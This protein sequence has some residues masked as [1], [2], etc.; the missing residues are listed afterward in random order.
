MNTVNIIISFSGRKLGNSGKIAELCRNT[1]QN[2]A[3]YFF[4]DFELHPCGDCNGECFENRKS[5]P[6]FGD[7]EESLIDAICRSDQAIFIVP[8]HCNYPNA[9]FFIFNERSQCSFQGEPDRLEQYLK[10]PK[11]FIVI[12]NTTKDGFDEIF[13]QHTDEAPQILFLSAKAYGKSSIA[14]DIL[15]STQ[16]REDIL[17][18]LNF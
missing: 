7:M 12:S 9:N 10:V 11:K 8:N 14:G 6:Y 3:A 16:A 15:E 1:I 13:T 5:C 17:S 18:F 4:S 2:S